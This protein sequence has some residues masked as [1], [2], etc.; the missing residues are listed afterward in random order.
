MQKLIAL[1]LA[2]LLGSAGLVVS[3]LAH[4]S[5]GKQDLQLLQKELANW[6]DQA[7][8]NSP[9]TASYTISKLDPRL[10]LDECA[11]IEVSLPQGYR[12]IGKTMLRAK[13]MQGANWSVNTPVQITMLVQYLV[14]ARPVGANQTLAESDLMFQRGDL[15]TLPGSV[16]MDA[17]QA[18]GRTLNTAIAAG[19]P[20][21][22]EHLRAAMVIQQNQRVRIVY[23]EDGL[24]IRNEGIALNNAAEGATVR[25][26]VGRNMILTGIAQAGGVVE[27][28]P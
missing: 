28:S 27:V 17:T 9:G 25:V 7:L 6:L 10:Q 12:L 5:S 13:C 16:L 14:A 26:R 8:L 11:A 22:K 21:R 19:Q 15:G 4:A 18:I 2:L 20:I 1:F 3:P 24:E 23:R